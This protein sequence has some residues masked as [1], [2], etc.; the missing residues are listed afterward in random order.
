MSDRCAIC[1]LPVEYVDRR[2]GRV[3]R[4]KGAEVH[5]YCRVLITGSIPEC[6]LSGN[7]QPLPEC[8]SCCQAMNCSKPG[9]CGC[10]NMVCQIGKSVRA[11]REQSKIP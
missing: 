4:Y 8:A 2:S 6:P 5:S 3:A 10:E 9:R 1:G 7:V 11:L